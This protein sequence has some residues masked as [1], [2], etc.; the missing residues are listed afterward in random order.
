MLN[1]EPPKYESRETS[2]FAWKLGAGMDL[3]AVGVTMNNPGAPAGYRQMSASMSS[4]TLVF[5][6]G[7]MKAFGSFD[8]PTDW[9][10][11]AV[12]FD[13]AP[14]WQQTTTTV[15]VAGAK[16]QTS[17]SFNVTGFA[18]NFESGSMQSM[19]AKMGKKARMKLTLFF[20]PP[21]GDLP[22]LMSANIGATWY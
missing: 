15:N 14:S 17:S 20:L 6:L 13:W 5:L 4:F 3:G 11:F 10:G 16:P 8:S 21:T 7:G 9:S 2:W 1:L 18:I 22:F 19:A 12:G